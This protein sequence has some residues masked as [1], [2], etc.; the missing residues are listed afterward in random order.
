MLGFELDF[1]DCATF[2]TA[3]LAGIAVILTYVC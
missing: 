2:A 1:W 3:A